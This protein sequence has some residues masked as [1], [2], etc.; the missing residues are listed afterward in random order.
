MNGRAAGNYANLF[1]GTLLVREVEVERE[2]GLDG[3][4][5]GLD[6]RRWGRG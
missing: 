2:A 4:K 5:E 6:L 1:K 3:V